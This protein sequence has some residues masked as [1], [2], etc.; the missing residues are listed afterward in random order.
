MNR[1]LYASSIASL[2]LLGRGKVRENYAVGDDRILMVASDRISAFDVVMD[3]PIPGKGEVL[4]R[5]ALFWFAHLGDVVPNHLTG[6]D[7]ASVVRADE[8][9]QVRGRSMVVRRLTPLPIEAVVRGEVPPRALIPQVATVGGELLLHRVLFL[10]APM[11]DDAL[12]DIID[13]VILPMLRGLGTEAPG[14]PG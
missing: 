13:W 12:A 8:A 3:E 4:T 7:P 9:A 5:M 14:D 6:L 11:A 10:G 2:P 1:A